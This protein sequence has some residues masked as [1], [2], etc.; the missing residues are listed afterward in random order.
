MKEGTV[1]FVSL[2][3]YYSRL[4]GEE[5]YLHTEPGS[6]AEPRHSGQRLGLE[7]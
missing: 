4:S 2:S 7:H 3:Y 5:P 1:D 6:G